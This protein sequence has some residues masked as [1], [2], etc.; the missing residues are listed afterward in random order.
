MHRRTVV[1]D[2]FSALDQ[3]SIAQEP[4]LV[5]YSLG[6]QVS[7]FRF[8]LPVALKRYGKCRRILLFFH[9]RLPPLLDQ[10]VGRHCH[11]MLDTVVCYRFFKNT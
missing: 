11:C 6:Y 2:R 5:Y 7:P 10:S 9:A 8:H 3:R 4:S 1:L